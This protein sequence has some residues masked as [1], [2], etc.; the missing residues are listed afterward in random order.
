MA[1]DVRDFEPRD[2]DWARRLIGTHQGGDHRVAR[3]GELLDPLE[4]EGIVAEMDGRPVG[5]LTVHESD[6]G[7]EVLT[8]RL[9]R[10]VEVAKAEPEPRPEERLACGKLL[11]RPEVSRAYWDGV[12]LGLTLGEYNIV[13]LLVQNPGSYVTYRAIYDRMHHEGFIAGIGPKGFWANVRSAIK[14]IRNKFREQDPTF[15]EIENY[16]GF[17]YCWRKPAS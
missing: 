9:R 16:T 1:L 7:L 14:R 6:R 13:H 15:A 10:V 8:K 12:D 11:L 2:H 4:H 17:G 5:L 3:L